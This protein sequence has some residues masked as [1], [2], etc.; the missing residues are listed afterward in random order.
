MVVFNKC[1]NSE[2]QRIKGQILK[3]SKY[4]VSFVD[5][6]NPVEAELVNL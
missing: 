5:R 3:A 1:N 2:T 6:V 4:E